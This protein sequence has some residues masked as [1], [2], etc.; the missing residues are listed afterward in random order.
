M[1]QTADNNIQPVLH[2]H[3]GNEEAGEEGSFT[4][5]ELAELPKRV[6]YAIDF[7][8][9]DDNALGRYQSVP[10]YVI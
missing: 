2:F 8:N 10:S 7:V 3:V 9:G 5:D 1:P 4:M 6:T